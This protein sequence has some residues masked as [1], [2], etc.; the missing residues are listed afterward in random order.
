M[1]SRFKLE[2]FKGFDRSVRVRVTAKAAEWGGTATSAEVK[3]TGYL[4]PEAALEFAEAL[5]A[6]ATDVAARNA[7]KAT[8][9][10]RRRARLAK[11]PKIN[12]H[13]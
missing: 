12:L 11:L 10:E 4:T 9:E 1:T 3:I 6:V 2:S 8:A 13:D 7:K 5:K